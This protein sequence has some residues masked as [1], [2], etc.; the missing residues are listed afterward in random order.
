[1]A[2]DRGER[3]AQLVGHLG[4]GAALAAGLLLGAVRL[5]ADGLEELLERVDAVVRHRGGQH[6]RAHQARGQRRRRGRRHHHP[7]DRR[8]RRPGV[9]RRGRVGDPPR[10][11]G[12]RRGGGPRA[13]D[14][15]RGGG[16]R[17]HP[18]HHLGRVRAPRERVH[19]EADQQ[20]KR[21]DHPDRDAV[22]LHLAEPAAEGQVAGHDLDGQRQR[23]DEG[24]PRHPH[25]PSPQRPPRHHAPFPR[26]RRHRTMPTPTRV[27]EVSAWSSPWNGGRIVD[28][29]V[30]RDLLAQ[31]SNATLWRVEHAQRGS[32]HVL[33]VLHKADGRR[34]AR[35]QQE[36]VLGDQ[37][38]HRNIV[39]C[40]Q[41]VEV[42]NHAGLILDY[43]DGPSPRSVAAR[44][45][46]GRPRHAP[47]DLPRAAR[48]RGVRA[49]EGRG[50]TAASNPRTCC[51]RRRWSTTAWIWWSRSPTSAW[52][53]PWRPRWASTGGLT[54]VNTGLGTWGY[55]APEQIRDASTVDHRADVYS[56]GCLLYELVCGVPP[57]AHLNQFEA[58]QAQREGRFR[59][60]RALV[61]GPARVAVH[62]DRGL[63]SRP[64]RIAGPGTWRR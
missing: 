38:Q 34:R 19:R 64:S 41:L 9:L 33:K 60:P 48:R 27:V 44:R 14:D 10:G 61:P 53:R 18:H 43:I 32:L 6:L 12:R 56:L 2:D 1:V 31:S 11:D 16:G 30:I 58:F 52:P 47:A 35:L 46:A 20:R 36:V 17:D 55:A 15:A 7:R 39:R 54:T 63:P 29:Y 4:H 51:S 57:F 28:G 59:S 45:S 26:H 42:S 22:G 62:A 3:R 21:L 23:G 5:L 50:S 8:R 13:F 25:Q 37:L 24:T 49:L 40:T